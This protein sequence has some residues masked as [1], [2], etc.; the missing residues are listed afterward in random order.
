ML[1]KRTKRKLTRLIKANSIAL[2]KEL[3]WFRLV[4]D[5]RFKLY[6]EQETEYQSIYDI[7]PPKR[8]GRSNWVRLLRKYKPDFAERLTLVLALIPHVAPRLL[9]VFHTK[10]ALF[11]RPF[12]EFGGANNQGHQGFI[13]TVETCLFL[14]SGAELDKR[15]AIMSM[16]QSDHFL[17]KDNLIQLQSMKDKQSGFQSAQLLGISEDILAYVTH[18]EE[19]KPQFDHSFPANLLSTH[20]KW[21]D[22]V[23][24]PATKKQIDEMITWIKHGHT[25]LYDWK[26]LGKIRPGYRALFYGPPGTGKT[27][28]ASLL[29]QA[30]SRDVYRVDLSQVVSKY[31]GETEK[32]LASIFDKAERKDWILFFDEADALF[33]KR[34]ETKSANDRYA[35]QEVSFLLQR[36]E[37]FDGIVI[38]ATN[39]KD[40]IDEAFTRRFEAMIHFPMPE[41][42]ERLRIWQQGFS[43]KVSFSEDVDLE[44]L[45][46]KVEMSGGNIMNVIRYVSMEALEKETTE[47]TM[48]MLRVGIRRE[49]AKSGRI[50]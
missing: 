35:N 41:V 8:S 5:T 10:N 14:L 28:T 45:A 9:D 16:F 39:F 29:G 24:K 25:L 20:L 40:N 3:S 7:V 18:G 33:G 17:I 1:D 38:L 43:H 30:T 4:L 31:I 12:T 49:L 23:L 42:Q 44:R 21:S 48:E 6:F 37:Q 34:S 50:V 19:S 13:P 27:L 22:V 2:E 46:Q 15:M 47:I 32:N 26:M 36:I 11:D